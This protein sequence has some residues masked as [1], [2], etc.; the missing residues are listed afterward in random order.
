[1]CG[2]QLLGPGTVIT[3]VRWW[4]QSRPDPWTRCRT[5]CPRD[6]RA[7]SSRCHQAAGDRPGV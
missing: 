1:M 7:W 4:R 3:A 5:R 6:R 2:R